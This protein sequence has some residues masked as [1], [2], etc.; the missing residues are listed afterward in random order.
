MNWET[1]AFQKLLCF[2][3]IRL[4]AVMMLITTATKEN[5]PWI[6]GTNNIIV[7]VSS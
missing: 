3:G 7:D 5:A 2:Y 1:F 4:L 6:E